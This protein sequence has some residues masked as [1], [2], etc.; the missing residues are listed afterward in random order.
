MPK[1]T[2]GNNPMSTELSKV[3]DWGELN[4]S[5]EFAEL[6]KRLEQ[7]INL[8]KEVQQEF[9]VEF[10]KDYYHLCSLE[11]EGPSEDDLLAP[12]N[13]A[14]R[15]KGEAR[16]SNRAANASSA[17]DTQGITG[18]EKEMLIAEAVAKE[19]AK[20]ATEH[21]K[22]VEIAKKEREEENKKN[23]EAM[24]EMKKKADD[25]ENARIIAV[26]EHERDKA[27]RKDEVQRTR[28]TA[29]A[30]EIA[31][32]NKAAALE[33]L[34]RKHENGEELEPEDFET[35]PAPKKRKTQE[36]LKEERL[37]KLIE[38]TGDEEEARGLH[39]EKELQRAAKAEERKEVRKE[40]VR[41][42]V[43]S[44]LVKEKN[45]LLEQKDALEE[46]LSMVNEE[47]KESKRQQSK[48]IDFLSLVVS[49]VQAEGKVPDEKVKKIKKSAMKQMEKQEPQELAGQQ[50]L[51]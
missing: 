43:A 15:A 25:S 47:F 50:E 27:E 5:K 18:T 45:V 38:K 24:V 32:A 29:K 1:T 40:K 35:I 41:E 49:K 6:G 11:K 31:E 22:E 13:G 4:I 8:P 28:N 17:A 39:E 26:A 21:A 42:Q 9:L 2:R 51:E 12:A 23:E 20:L 14:K 37:Q 33:N 19:R 44:E 7:G 36:E 30:I 16:V 48:M 3:Y 46:T 10:R 34:R